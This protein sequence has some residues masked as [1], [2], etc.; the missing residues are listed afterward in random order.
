MV[1]AKRITI[2]EP[3]VPDIRWHGQLFAIA[4]V[5]SYARTGVSHT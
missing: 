4:G 2:K 3:A 5:V 1:F